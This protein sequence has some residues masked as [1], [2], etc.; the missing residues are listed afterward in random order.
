M[1][2]TTQPSIVL[3]AVQ[4]HWGWYMVPC[5]CI[6]K[7][8]S[9]TKPSKTGIGQFKKKRENG[10]WNDPDFAL[11]FLSILRTRKRMVSL[12]RRKLESLARKGTFFA[13]T[14]YFH[15]FSFGFSDGT[16]RT[17]LQTCQCFYAN[18]A[19]FTFNTKMTSRQF[20]EVGFYLGGGVL[21]VVLS[22]K[23][24]SSSLLSPSHS[25]WR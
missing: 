14:L 13:Q 20:R 25:H 2:A 11:Q 7:F 16:N 19:E 9:I 23:F 6:Y 21:G 18:H 8:F 5:H 17:G 12:A 15:T 24:Q 4:Q 10:E 1:C 22:G 3:T